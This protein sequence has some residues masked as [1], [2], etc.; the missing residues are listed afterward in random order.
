MNFRHYRDKKIIAL[1]TCTVFRIKIFVTLTE[2]S[3]TAW[4][5]LVGLFK[6]SRAKLKKL[7]TDIMFFRIGS[8]SI[9][10]CTSKIILS[11]KF[12]VMLI[13]FILNYIRIK[14]FI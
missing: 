8:Y 2:L 9:V 14:I 4:Q 10:A 5:F 12:L 11:R 1:Q 7:H 6:Q 3:Y 13:E